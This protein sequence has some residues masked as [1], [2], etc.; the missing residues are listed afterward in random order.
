MTGPVAVCFPDR[1][2]RPGPAVSLLDDAGNRAEG[3]PGPTRSHSRLGSEGDF[4]LTDVSL[5]A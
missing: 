4:A 5:G 3:A 2:P 1:T